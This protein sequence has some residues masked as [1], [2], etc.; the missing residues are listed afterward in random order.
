MHANH[1]TQFRPYKPNRQQTN[2]IIMS[3]QKKLNVA[4]S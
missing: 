1:L 3:K 2:K 4:E